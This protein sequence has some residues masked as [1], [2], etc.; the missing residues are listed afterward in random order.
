MKQPTRV[1]S[2][3]ETLVDIILTSNPTFVIESGVKEIFISDNFLTYSILNLKMPKSQTAYITSRSYTQYDPAR[4]IEDLKQVSWN[5]MSCISAVDQKLYCFNGYLQKVLNTH[6]P[7]KTMKVK[8]RQCSFVNEEIKRSMRIRDILHK[9]VRL[10]RDLK[11]WE[12]FHLSRDYIKKSLK[13]A[14]RVYVKN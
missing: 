4:F 9:R 11:D 14:E 5:E 6:A 12:M 7:V 2:Q 1:T 3:S 8:Y 13:E 10:T